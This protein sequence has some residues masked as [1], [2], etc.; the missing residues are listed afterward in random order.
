MLTFIKKHC[1]IVF[2]V[3]ISIIIRYQKL[4]IFSYCI[5]FYF[6]DDHCQYWLNKEDGTLTSPNI[7]LNDLG[8]SQHYD[9]NLNCTW[10]LNTDEEF[11]ITL[12]I[13]FFFVMNND[14]NDIYF[15][16]FSNKVHH[17]RSLWVTIFQS[18]MNQ[19]F[20][21]CHY[22]NWICIPIIIKKVFQVQDLTCWYNL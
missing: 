16:N 15:Y 4:H 17:F 13:T 9:H 5:N 2:K 10:I 18:M 6:I 3:H 11:Y 22:Q 14:T 8:Y 21:H 1:L 20:N 7:G 12:E 19:I